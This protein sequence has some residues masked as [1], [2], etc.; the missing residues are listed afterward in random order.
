MKPKDLNMIVKIDYGHLY[1][2]EENLNSI[3]NYII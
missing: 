3:N 1:P 2:R